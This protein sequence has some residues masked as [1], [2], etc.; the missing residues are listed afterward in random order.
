MIIFTRQKSFLTFKS[1]FDDNYNIVM[2]VSDKIKKV[3]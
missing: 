2:I 3:L 1:N